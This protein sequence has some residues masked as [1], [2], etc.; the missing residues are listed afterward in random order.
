MASNKQQTC[1]PEAMSIPNNKKQKVNHTGTS[2]ASY[3]S[4]DA[5]KIVNPKHLIPD[6]RFCGLEVPLPSVLVNII[7]SYMTRNDL[8]YLNQDWKTLPGSYFLENQDL[9]LLLF[10]KPTWSLEHVPLMLA[11]EGL[12]DWLRFTVHEMKYE[13][14]DGNEISAAIAGHGHLETLRWAMTHGCTWDANTSS[15]AAS[16]GYL[17]VL[18]RANDNGCPW[19]TTTC[20]HAAAGGHLPTLQ[21]A[22]ANGCPWDR[23]TCS[24]AAGQGH[25]DILQWARENGCPWDE[26]TCSA[27]AGQGHLDTLQW[28]RVNGCPWDEKTCS[29]AAGAGR[30]DI[31]QWARSWGCPWDE[32]TCSYAASQGHLYVLKWARANGCPWDADTCAHAAGVK[33]DVLA[34]VRA[35]GY[36]LDITFSCMDTSYSKRSQQLH[37]L[38]WANAHG[39]TVGIQKPYNT[40]VPAGP[41]NLEIL[42]WARANGCAWDTETCSWAAYGGKL[43][44]LQWARAN[45]CSWN[46]MTCSSAAEMGYLEILKWARTNGC[47]WDMDTCLFA[48]FNGHVDILQWARAHKCPWNH[49]VIYTAVEYGQL[50]V[51]QWSYDNGWPAGDCDEDYICS[52]AALYGHLDTLKWARSIGCEW[53]NDGECIS[54]DNLEILQW[55]IVNGCPSNSIS[56]SRSTFAWL[57]ANDNPEDYFLHWLSGQESNLPPL[58]ISRNIRTSGR[59]RKPI[60]RY[61]AMVS[62]QPRRV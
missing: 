59:K 45:G 34:W 28:A 29:S 53:D 46:A 11:K 7:R 60:Q 38:Q 10:K 58:I 50:E 37:I 62:V 44:I 56:C 2:P 23:K 6:R 48:A 8:K 52:S 12:F 3:V 9:R 5:S 4:S 17:E 18:Q 36:P 33:I 49:E 57:Q 32:T 26:T 41:G 30:L 61:A 31:L 43:E 15:V 42:Q 22:S 20:S 35:N 27:A 55:A 25:L 39:L 51:L 19:D 1:K 47:P 13:W 21:W 16:N 54:S 14:K 40:Q 24:S